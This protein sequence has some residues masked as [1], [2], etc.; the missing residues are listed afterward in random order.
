V[1][2]AVLKNAVPSESEINE[3]VVEEVMRRVL[4]TKVY[5][6]MHPRLFEGHVVNQFAFTDATSEQWATAYECIRRYTELCKEK[7]T[8]V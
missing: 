4:E 5:E 6:K 7:G 1:W 3:E 8:F 2:E